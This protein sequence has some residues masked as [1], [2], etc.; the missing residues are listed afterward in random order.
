[1]EKIKNDEVF[2]RMNTQKSIWNTLRLRKKVWIGHVIRNSPWITTIIKGKIEEKPGR[3]RPR[4]PF[5]KQVMEDNGIG[6]ILGDEKDY[7]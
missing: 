6:I 5:L 1:M 3:G 2:R 7:N 4:T